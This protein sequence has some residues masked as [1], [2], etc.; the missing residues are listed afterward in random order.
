MGGKH[1]HGE[2]AMYIIN[3]RDKTKTYITKFF[4]T[5]PILYVAGSE[6]L[7]KR[8]LFPGRQDFAERFHLIEQSKSRISDI[9]KRDKTYAGSGQD[10]LLD[11]ELED[12]DPRGGTL[13]MF[14]SVTLPHEVLATKIRNV[15]LAV[16][17]FRGSTARYDVIP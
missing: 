13:V 11:E 15:G 12:V 3:E 17:G 16:A 7:A 10:A 2:C 1:N 14:D 9:L 8:V 4:E 5:N 6:I